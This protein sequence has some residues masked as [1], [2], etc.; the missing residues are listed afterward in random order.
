MLLEV[1]SLQCGNR[2]KLVKIVP[3]KV[4]NHLNMEKMMMIELKSTLKNRTSKK[5]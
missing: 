3:Q 1:M 2:K 4:V 5:Q